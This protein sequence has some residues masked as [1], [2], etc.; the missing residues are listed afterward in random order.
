MTNIIAPSQHLITPELPDQ[1]LSYLRDG[2]RDQSWPAAIPLPLTIQWAGDIRE[3][4][5]EMEQSVYAEMREC[6][7]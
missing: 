5:E 3:A 1:L 2:A 7:G 4:M 6:T